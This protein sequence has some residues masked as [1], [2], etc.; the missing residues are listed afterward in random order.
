MAPATV[1]LTTATLSPVLRLALLGAGLSDMAAPVPSAMGWASL[2][3]SRVTLI[4]EGTGWGSAHRSMS[5][6]PMIGGLPPVC[7]R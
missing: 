5:R 1:F 2:G 3:N 6:V 7:S 4:S